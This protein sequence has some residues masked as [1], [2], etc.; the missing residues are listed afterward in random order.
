M[1]EVKNFFL[2]RYVLVSVGSANYFHDSHL[3]ELLPSLPGANQVLYVVGKSRAVK[4]I[5]LH[6]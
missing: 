5:K 3:S 2:L 1:K 6:V 4:N